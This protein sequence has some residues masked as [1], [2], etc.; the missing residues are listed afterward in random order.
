M[1]DRSRYTAPA[2]EKGLDI[3][4]LL[5]SRFEPMSQA[6]IAHA[7]GRTPSEVFR[8]I[9]VLEQRGYLVRG[10]EDELYCLSPRLFELA[11]QHPPSR[12]L[13]GAAIPVM[14]ALA[15]RIQ[16][17][18]HLSV[19]FSR[20]AVV[21]AQVD[22]PGFIGF[23]VRVGARAP[24]LDSCSGLTLLAFRP[25]WEDSEAI[26]FDDEV[27]RSDEE[28]RLLL[29]ELER[30]R[31][32]GHTRVPSLIT[33]GITDIASPVLDHAGCAMASLTVP[34]LARVRESPS[35]E[36]AQAAVQRAASEVTL[37]LGGQL[38]HP[39]P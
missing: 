10:A 21:I 29:D 24:M 20:F 16:Q 28:R 30:I 38:L 12:H 26:F 27:E 32:A 31:S 1:T 6:A 17:S 19:R 9:A 36:R 5:A 7:L 22:P 8:M 34:Y 3:I 33:H 2:L 39:T 14:H 13:L 37:S 4:E 18:C 11:H 25:S 23:S 35:L 15:A